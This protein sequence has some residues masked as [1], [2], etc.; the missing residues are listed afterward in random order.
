[1]PGGGACDEWLPATSEPDC[2]SSDGTGPAIPETLVGNVEASRAER[3]F[4]DED[5]NRIWAHER[6]ERRRAGFDLAYYSQFRCN[7]NRLSDFANLWP[8]TRDLYQQPRVAST[9]DVDA[10]KGI[11]YGSRPPGILPKGPLLDFAA[12]HQ[13]QQL[14]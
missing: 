6:M 3:R 12:P 9:V 1:M 11:Y 4:V 7:R 13:R 2:T 5:M 8:Y 10:I 14:G